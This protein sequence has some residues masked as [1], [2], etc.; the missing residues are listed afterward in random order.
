MHVLCR[1][2]LVL[3]VEDIKQSDIEE[4]F[5]DTVRIGKY[6]GESGV[7][8][9]QRSSETM[10]HGSVTQLAEGIRKIVAA[11]SDADPNNVAKRASWFDKLL[12]R[13]VERQVR[14]HVA[15]KNLDELLAQT[16]SI[17]QQVFDTLQGLDA[18]VAAHEQEH[19]RL[20]AYIDAGTQFL[21]ENPQAGL[22]P[23]HEMQ[24][25]KPRD[26]FQRKLGNLTTLLASHEMTATQMRLSRAV[27][28]DMLD[29]YTETATV[30]VPVWRQHTLALM[31]TSHATPE[32]LALANK[33]H[34][35]LMNSLSES[36]ASL[37]G[38][39]RS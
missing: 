5:R 32:S 16:E 9:L 39:G 10:E 13:E 22:A 18:L 28:I 23:P 36:L 2:S 3:L 7:A 29:R 35:A 25:D 38:K 24:F 8:L 11:L 21:R 20:K 26:R 34:A 30:L 12:G 33:A 17:A 37:D 19:A 4:L 31:S 6:G 15:K 1:P 14:Y 27:A